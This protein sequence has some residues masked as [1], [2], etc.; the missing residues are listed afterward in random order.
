MILNSK[1]QDIKKVFEICNNLANKHQI[2]YKTEGKTFTNFVSKDE[3]LIKYETIEKYVTSKYFKNIAEKY[4]GT[5]PILADIYLMLSFPTT[6]R[7][8]HSQLWHL[9]GD[10]SK[11]CTFYLYCSDVDLVSGPFRLVSKKK[12]QKRYFPKFLI[13]YGYT[14]EL[15]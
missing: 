10:D 7:Q 3:E 1:F 11:I 13:I 9:D 14:D 2:E 5:V 15:F 4:L 6:E 8:N 12:S